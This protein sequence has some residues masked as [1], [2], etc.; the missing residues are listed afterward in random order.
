[1]AVI[2]GKRRRSTMCSLPNVWHK[3]AEKSAEVGEGIFVSVVVT[4]FQFFDVQGEVAGRDPFEQP[5][6]ALGKGPE[7]FGGVD[8][9]PLVLVHDSGV[10]GQTAQKQSIVMFVRSRV[11]DLSQG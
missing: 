4:E 5:E 10:L 1:M 8:S 7:P 6:P 11:H 3:G 9:Q 2:H